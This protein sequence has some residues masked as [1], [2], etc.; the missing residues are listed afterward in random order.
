M[1]NAAKAQDVWKDTGESVSFIV[2]KMKR[3]N[4]AAEQA[5][6]AEFAD[7]SQ[8]IIRSLKIRAAQANL[9]V[10]IGFS[11]KA[12]QYLFPK[13]TMPKEL[14]TYTTL[15]GP[16][17]SMPASDGDIFLHIRAKDEAIVYEAVRQFMIFLQPATNLI[18][19]TK[20][21]RYLE[22]RAIIGFVDGTEAPGMEDAAEYAIIGD[23]DPNFENGSYAFAQ[24]WLH[25]MSN[26][27]HNATEVQEKAV[28]RHKFDD[29]ELEDE[30]KFKNAHNVASKI[31]IDGVEQKI[32]R[33]NVPFSNPAAGQT[34]TYFIGYARH[35]Q[36]TKQMLQQMLDKSDFLLSFSTLL[37]GQLF[38]IPSRDNLAE[39][40][41]GK[42]F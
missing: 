15:T 23:E 37:S 31:E 27:E 4:L 18:D 40:A 28:G 26:W 41:D 12:W 10:A 1:I 35:W 16:K 25:D 42:Y 19:E 8:A 5:E 34:G 24:K 22:G 9:R 17:Y 33:M 2:L 11:A 13:V 38:F 14:E 30:D 3:E 21:F 29:L 6:I 39:I 36:V 32:V 7:R 20:G